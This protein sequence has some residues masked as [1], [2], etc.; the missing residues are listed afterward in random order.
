MSSAKRWI[1]WEPRCRS[2][3]TRSTRRWAA[4]RWAEDL[5]LLLTLA[6][7]VLANPV[8]PEDEVGRVRDQT[9]TVLAHA[10]DS[11]GSRAA[12]RFRELLYGPANPN[13]WPEDGYAKTVRQFE[14]DDLRSFH[15]RAFAP[16]HAGV[17]GG[18]RGGSAG[19]SRSGR[20]NYRRLG[21]AA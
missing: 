16:R 9:L 18:W 3:P 7:D 8:F 17:G 4:A 1:R 21:T 11:P 20:A 5:A 6:T 10:E 19:R 12:R 13:G 15:A 14:A 2:T